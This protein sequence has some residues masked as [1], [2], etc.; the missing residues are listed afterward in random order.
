MA[1]LKVIF[2]TPAKKIAALK[3]TTRI[4]GQMI[5]TARSPDDT[6]SG[7]EGSNKNCAATRMPHA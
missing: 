5:A 3:S 7:D 1:V 2:A 4:L 6:N